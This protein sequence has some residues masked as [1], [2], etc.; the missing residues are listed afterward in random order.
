MDFLDDLVGNFTGGKSRKDLY[1]GKGA[2]DAW[3][4]KG[5]GDAGNALTRGRGYL[6]QA[7]DESLPYITQGTEEVR[8]G[9]GDARGKRLFPLI[10]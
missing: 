6:R 3:L 9:Y 7:Y 5:Y 2:S 10:F 4:E 8:R 1:K